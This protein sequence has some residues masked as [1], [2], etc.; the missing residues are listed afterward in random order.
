ME[1]QNYLYLEIHLLIF[2]MFDSAK[3]FFFLSPPFC[4]LTNLKQLSKPSCFVTLA[5]VLNFLVEALDFCF[6]YNDSNFALTFCS[7]H[8]RRLCFYFEIKHPNLIYFAVE[9]QVPASHW[10]VS[11][12]KKKRF[13]L[14]L[15]LKT[16]PCVIKM[17]K[18]ICSC[19]FII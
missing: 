19:Y 11:N 14:P 3:F 10:M 12:P 16:K 6:S 8:K 18:V 4:C 1:F 13:D 2:I 15:D 9:N 17:M 7:F 5:M